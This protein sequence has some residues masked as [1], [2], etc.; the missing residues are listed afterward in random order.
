MSRKSTREWAAEG[1]AYPPVPEVPPRDPLP[2]I[3][4]ASGLYSSESALNFLT[5][6]SGSSLGVL[7][8]V[9]LLFPSTAALFE[10]LGHPSHARYPRPIPRRT[11]RLQKVLCSLLVA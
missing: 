7:L 6:P 4:S 10:S 2:W 8:F 3:G 5:S 11:P 1:G 9:S